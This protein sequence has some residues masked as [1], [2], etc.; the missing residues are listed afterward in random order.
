MSAYEK[1]EYLYAMYFSKSVDHHIILT[2]F[3]SYYIEKKIN[4]TA[5]YA[6]K[7]YRKFGIIQQTI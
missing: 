5:I 3:R 7:I 6:L 4:I 2:A 1:S